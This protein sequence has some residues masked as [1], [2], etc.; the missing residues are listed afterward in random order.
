MVDKNKFTNGKESIEEQKKHLQHADLQNAFLR[1]AN[2]SDANL[3]YA[4]LRGANLEHAELAYADLRGAD[5]RGA[6]MT[7][8]RFFKTKVRKDTKFNI[9]D[10]IDV[11]VHGLRGLSAEIT[12]KLDSLRLDSS[13]L[14][15]SGK[16]PIPK[17]HGKA[18]NLENKT[19]L[20][21]AF[22]ENPNVEELAN[23]FQRSER[24][25]AFQIE[26]FLDG[27]HEN[28]DSKF[29]EK[30]RKI[31]N[32]EDNKNGN[33]QKSN[34]KRK[35]KKE[36]IIHFMMEFI[37]ENHKRFSS[38]EKL[39]KELTYLVRAKFPL[40]DKRIQNYI[41]IALDDL[42]YNHSLDFQKSL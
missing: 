42:R 8:I 10:L 30:C 4:D 41:N 40:G 23:L 27:A 31:T 14:Q 7:D 22:L 1:Y 18:W 29:V 34:T 12:R 38:N 6:K 13:K 32:L 11:N 35:S 24:S 33:I 20:K 3:E 36:L 21:T 25:I 9:E 37:L 5:L 16:P 19:K 2:L 15:I 39:L 28:F 17:N 26:S